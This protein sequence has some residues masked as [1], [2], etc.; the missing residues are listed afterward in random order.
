MTDSKY[1][2]QRQPKTQPTRQTS[3]F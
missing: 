1:D 3:Q 2:R